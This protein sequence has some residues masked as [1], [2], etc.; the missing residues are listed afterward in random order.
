LTRG[1]LGLCPVRLRRTPQDIFAKK[2]ALRPCWLIEV[3]THVRK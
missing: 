3:K 1:A 2:K